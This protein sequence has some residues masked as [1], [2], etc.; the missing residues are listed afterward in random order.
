MYL[1]HLLIDAGDNPD[2]PRPGRLWLRNAYRVHQR[3]CMAFPSSVSKTNDPAFLQPYRP[4]SVQETSPDRP[5]VHVRRNAE[6]NFLFRMDPHPG[7]RMVILVQSALQ[8]DWDYAF[9]NSRF[10][11]ATAPECKAFQPAYSSGQRLRFRLVANPTKKVDTKSSADG[12]RNNGRRVPLPA[13]QF[14][15]WLVRRSEKSGFTVNQDSLVA[16]RGFVYV[17]KK[18]QDKGQSLVSVRYEGTLQVA[19]YERF[20]QTL[21]QGIGPAKAFGFGLLS[22]ARA[23]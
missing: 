18:P 14:N 17:N 1:S 4:G 12:K 6:H 9:Q 3:L 2:R 5:V 16:Q 21:I 22:V 20:H 10:L 15:E 7:G 11:L 19:D 8:P 13:D 23:D